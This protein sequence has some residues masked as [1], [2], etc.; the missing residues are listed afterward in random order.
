MSAIWKEIS[1]GSV[2]AFRVVIP[3]PQ[4]RVPITLRTTPQLLC[5]YVPLVF[6]AYLARRPDTYLIRLLLLPTVVICALMSGFR[7]TANIAQLNVYDW[8]LALLAEVIIAKALQYGLTP[9]GML[10]L[11]ERRPGEQ[12]GKEVDQSSAN[13]HVNGHIE[14]PP[15]R[16]IPVWICDAFELIHTMRA[17]RWKYAQGTHIPP[18]IRPLERRAF[19]N[20]TA[21]SFVKN[22]LILDFI[23]SCVKLFPG[24]GEPV[25]GSIFYNELPPIPRYVVSTT[26]HMLTGSAI[27]AGFGMVYDLLTFLAVYLFSTPPSAWP[28]ATDG[29]WQASSLTRLWSKHWHQF[30]RSTFL[31][32][33][34]YPGR[35]LAGDIG[36]V[37]GTFIASGVYHEAAMYAM[38]RGFDHTVTWFFAIQGPLIIGERLFR[39]TT[40]RRVGGWPGR[41]WVYAVIFIGAQPMVDSWHKRGLGGAMVIPPVLSPVRLTLFTLGFGRR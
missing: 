9:E 35:W 3:K 19:L 10:K 16:I 15:T 12:K 27:L 36:W 14:P 37:L 2:R 32:Y 40:G 38:G 1:V 31:V 30:L 25:G 6:L 23:E 39:V 22:F 4:D 8:G 34:G 11:G 41:L 17:P 29:P 20:A 7:Y 5:L 26:I 33:G 28:P 13:G 18:H 24:V 21:R